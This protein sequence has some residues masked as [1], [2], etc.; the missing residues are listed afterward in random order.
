MLYLFGLKQNINLTFRKAMKELT[1]DRMEE[2]NGGR[3]GMADY[4]GMAAAVGGI[5]LLISF[6][7]AATA[8]AMGSGFVT[9]IGAGVTFSCLFY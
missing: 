7:P 8:V 9:G 5:A 1:I 3:C 2:L 4:L 6:P